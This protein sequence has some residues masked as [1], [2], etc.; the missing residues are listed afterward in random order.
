MIVFLI[1]IQKEQ[2]IWAV[3][4]RAKNRG[5]AFFA[6]LPHRRREIVSLLLEGYTAAEVGV[7]L[8]IS[9]KTVRNEAGVVVSKY[10]DLC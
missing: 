10:T 3:R 5:E 2:V 6:G 1:L 9:P 4:R 8:G 7:R